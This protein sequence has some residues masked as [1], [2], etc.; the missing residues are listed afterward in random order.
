MYIYQR[1]DWPIFHWNQD[2]LAN[3]LAAV[4]HRAH[5]T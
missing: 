3:Q 2:G 5:L 4:R 1:E